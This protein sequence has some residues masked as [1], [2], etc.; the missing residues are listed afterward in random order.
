MAKA[1]PHW[2]QACSEKFCVTLTSVEVE[3]VLPLSEGASLLREAE[4]AE[5]GA[6]PW[7]GW[8]PLSLW[9]VSG[10]VDGRRCCCWRS[11]VRVTGGAGAYAAAA[12]AAA[13]DRSSCLRTG[14][15]AAADSWSCLRVT[16]G[17]GGRG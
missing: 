16:G 12:A 4:P 1:R 6:W 10:G 13:G 2:S 15:G 14:G 9:R 3:P 8:P 5:E 17:E 7:S 11:W